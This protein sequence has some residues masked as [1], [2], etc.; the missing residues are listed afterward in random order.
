MMLVYIL[1]LA[2]GVVSQ[3][4]PSTCPPVPSLSPN[5]TLGQCPTSFTVIGSELEPIHESVDAPT[6]L[7]VDRDSNV[8]LTYPRN[9]GVTPVNVVKATSF[10][11][12]EAWPNVA[13]QNCTAQQDPAECFINVQNV[14]LDALG[15][16]WILDSGIP[17]GAKAAISRGAKIIAFSQNGETIRTYIVPDEFYYDSMN[18]NDL[19]I[20][21]TLGKGGYAF[22]TDASNSGSLLAINLHDGSVRRR[23]HN[24]TVT[25]ADA[26]Y[27]GS[28]N[29][30]PIY[31]WNNTKKSYATTGADGI[32]LAS[33][34]LYW[35]VLASRRFYFISQEALIDDSLSDNE[36]LAAVQDPGELGSEQAGFTADD[37]GRLYMLA[38]EQNAIY[39]VDTQQSQITEEVNATPLGGAG[40][41]PTE[42]YVVKTWLRSGLIQHAD[43][44]AILDGWLYFCT[45][46]LELGPQRQ[47]K[48]VDARRGPF[49]SYRS[50]IGRGP[51]L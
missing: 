22:I 16:L 12:E 50:W 11:S 24:T 44:A 23:L 2:A 14:V 39:Y 26:N 36:V 49:R 32:A 27:V 35:G 28:Y 43:S 21:N 4:F 20:N 42:D 33:G 17:P 46:Q 51:A 38:S 41:V 40:L 47:Y 10:T 5:T 3:G 19:R 34:N 48:N 30:E 45:N 9:G 37:H 31:I 18:A 8:Y 25:K 1:A 6:G 13:I 7:A 29:G 15:Q